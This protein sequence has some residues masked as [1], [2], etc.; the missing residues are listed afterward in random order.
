VSCNKISYCTAVVLSLHCC[1]G[2][3]CPKQCCVHGL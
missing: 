2:N 3:R 1:L